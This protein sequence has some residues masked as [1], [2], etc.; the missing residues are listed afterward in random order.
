MVEKI[1]SLWRQADLNKEKMESCLEK[2]ITLSKT[3]GKFFSNLV[4]TIEIRVLPAKYQ[5]K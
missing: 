5:R 1:I 4:D 2:F 3:Q